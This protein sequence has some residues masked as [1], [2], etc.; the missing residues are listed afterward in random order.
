MAIVTTMLSRSWIDAGQDSPTADVEHLR[1]FAL[2]SVAAIAFQYFLGGLIRHHGSGLHE[3]LAMG[4]V[5]L[6]LLLANAWLAMTSGVTW[7]RRGG[8]MLAVITV[9]QVLLGLGAWVLKFG[10]AATGYVAVADSIE[11]VSVRTAHALVGILTF[12]VSVV[13]TARVFRVHAVAKPSA[14]ESTVSSQ[15]LAGGAV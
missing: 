12:M 5:V 14:S 15:S 10:H 6:G 13:Y 7:I 3:H 4:F 8:A 9:V 2:L 11:Q 1:P